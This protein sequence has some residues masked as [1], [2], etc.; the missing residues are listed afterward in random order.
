MP[1]ILSSENEDCK[2]TANIIFLKRK[3]RTS[4]HIFHFYGKYKTY[5]F[6]KKC[7]NRGKGGIPALK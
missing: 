2:R 5:S 7:N 4:K 6:N 3:L 1:Y